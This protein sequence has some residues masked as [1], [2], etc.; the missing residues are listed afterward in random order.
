[1]GNSTRS[2]VNGSPVANS[3]SRTPTAIRHT[4]RPKSAG[5][6][7]R[8]ADLAVAERRDRSPAAAWVGLRS[9]GAALT[10]VGGRWVRPSPDSIPWTP[11]GERY[12]R[13]PGMTVVDQD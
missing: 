6:G 7:D 5:A 4:E 9:V 1:M 3:A 10:R 11:S 13:P 8:P 2:A 12:G